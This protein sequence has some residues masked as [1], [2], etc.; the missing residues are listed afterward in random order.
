VGPARAGRSCHEASPHHLS[1]AGVLVG[2]HGTAAL[3]PR[4]SKNPKPRPSPLAWLA[5]CSQPVLS[6]AA[7]SQVCHFEGGR[8]S[9]L[10]THDSVIREILS[11]FLSRP[12][13]TCHQLA[14]LWGSL[15]HLQDEITRVRRSNDEQ[16]GHA[17]VALHRPDRQ[18]AG[19]PVGRP[20][21]PSGRQ[22]GSRLCGRSVNGVD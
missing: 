12:Q 1:S 7:R 2:R 22:S 5:K 8:H 16:V 3:N 17:L 20:V 10:A 13:Y 21:C 4:P 18:I 19:Q 9:L 14:A 11:D 15:P 6:V